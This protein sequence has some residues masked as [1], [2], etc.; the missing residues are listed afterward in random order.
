MKRLILTSLV[1]AFFCTGFIFAEESAADKKSTIKAEK[2]ATAQR[3]TVSKVTIGVGKIEYRA[4]LSEADKNRRAYGIRGPAENTEAFV[5][6]LT[7]ALVKLKKFNVIERD[8]MNDLLKEQ[9]LGESG[10]I[11][12]STAHKLGSVQGIDYV[13]LGA[14]TQ[15]GIDKKGIGTRGLLGR[16]D[17]AAGR[18]KARMTVDIKIID[19]ETGSIAIA[20]TVTETAEGAKAIETRQVAA[21]SSSGQVLS[22]VMRKT[23]NS[24]V[25]LIV[26]T[27]YPIKIVNL[28][29]SGAIMLNYGSGLLQKKQVFDVFS[30]GEEIIDPDTGEVLGCE[31]EK[32][33][34]I[35]VTSVQAKFSKAKVL[36]G[37]DKIKRGM[38]CRLVSKEQLERE[39]KAKQKPKKKR[40]LF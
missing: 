30:Q 17:F 39:E 20:E 26:S 40:L 12:E 34:R 10:I 29:S 24:V 22:D 33:G 38:I 35:E 11:D 31:E 25:H 1:L 16:F 19:V 21:S 28:S 7:T 15:Y 27:L 5:D 23:A 3:P 9:A 13:L 6:M 18:E 8:R 36:V 2:P 14:I 32:I 37:A 4:E